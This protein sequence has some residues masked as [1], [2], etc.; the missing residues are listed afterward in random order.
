MDFEPAYR[1]SE[2]LLI[3]YFAM[4]II[5]IYPIA[6]LL[7]VIG[8]IANYQLDKYILLRKC[9]RPV[10]LSGELG[11]GI[12]YVIAAGWINYIMGMLLFTF[13]MP[14]NSNKSN[15]KMFIFIF[16]TAFGLSIENIL[17]VMSSRKLQEETIK[18]RSLWDE[19]DGGIPKAKEEDLD[20]YKRNNPIYSDLY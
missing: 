16:F 4:F 2:S 1:V 17:Q 19:E 9:K 11:F 7:A 5:P 15:L 13:N 6:P 10:F 18:R 14:F 12:I 3:F 20:V 8:M